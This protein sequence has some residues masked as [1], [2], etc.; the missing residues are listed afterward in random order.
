MRRGA[1]ESV[2]RAAREQSRGAGAT[3]L[4]HLV[5]RKGCQCV[6]K[7]AI[8]DFH[9][10]AKFSTVTSEDRFASNKAK[11][12]SDSNSGSP[13]GIEVCQPRLLGSISLPA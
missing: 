11:L 8:P 6:P 12:G 10:A 4:C 1:T 3:R 13:H 9:Q 7:T 5:E 2:A